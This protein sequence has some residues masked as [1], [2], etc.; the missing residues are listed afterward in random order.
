M[1]SHISEATKDESLAGKFDDVAGMISSACSVVFF[2]VFFFWFWFSPFP[3]LF[4]NIFW[5]TLSVMS[6][7]PHD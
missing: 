7:S 6:I 3:H 1:P 5:N 4:F 2:L